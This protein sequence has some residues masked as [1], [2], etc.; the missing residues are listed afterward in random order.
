MIKKS[1]IFLI[2]KNYINNLYE[3][4]TGYILFSHKVYN[5]EVQ[6]VIETFL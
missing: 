3:R 5:L 2:L 6:Y 4:V 1:Q